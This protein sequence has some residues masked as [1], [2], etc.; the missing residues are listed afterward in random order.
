MNTESKIGDLI[1]NSHGILEFHACDTLRSEL[2]KHR[3]KLLELS[4]TTDEQLNQSEYQ[5]T[6]CLQFTNEALIPFE[7]WVKGANLVRDI[8]MD[9][10]A[11]VT[12]AEF[13]G[14]KL[15]TGDR[16]LMRGLAK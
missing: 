8:D 9:D 14:I 11:F 6:N 15:W 5:I 10:I 3:P 13:L 16:E 7:F 12:L 1:M 2:K 4:K